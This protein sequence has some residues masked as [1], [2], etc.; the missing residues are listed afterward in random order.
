METKKAP[1]STLITY[2]ILTVTCIM[3]T[4][5]KY[6]KEQ[7]LLALDGLLCAI[8]ASSGGSI[9]QGNP[10]TIVLYTL[11]ML[12]FTYSL[13]LWHKRVRYLPP[14][15]A[16]AK[17]VR[18]GYLK[19][20]A[21]RNKTISRC[22]DL[23]PEAFG[24]P[25]KAFHVIILSHRWLSPVTC[26]VPTA[27]FPAGLKLTKLLQRLDLYFSPKGLT[28]GPGFFGRLARIRDSL[29]GGWDVLVFIDFMGLPQIT[30]D[31]KGGLVMRS[32]EDELVF[33]E[34]LANMSALYSTFPVLVMDEV[35][36]GAHPYLESGWCFS[37]LVVATLGNSLSPYSPDMAGVLAFQQ[38]ADQKMDESNAPSFEAA[39]QSEL[40]TK[41]FS[42]ETD[43][44]AVIDIMQD[45][46]NKRLLVD[47]IR[48]SDAEAVDRILSRFA[49]DRLQMVLDQPADPILSTP[50]HIA[51]SVNSVDITKLLLE[52]GARL[53]L[54]NLHGDL[55]SEWLLLPRL[56]A[57]ARLCAAARWVRGA[58]PGARGPVA[59][60]GLVSV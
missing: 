16:R 35:Q 48:A 42:D 32:A 54:R 7:N 12:P 41:K 56:R 43:A 13:L 10:A 40:L 37:E 34:C 31:D 59:S 14:G 39:F 30:T 4:F 23:P 15:L 8:A 25:G 1:C 21:A 50:L 2:G 29:M 44:T 36:Q 45:F 3:A 24:D 11:F 27:E 46:L 57:A 55:A 38:F 5:T 6:V 58:R 49:G 52:H 33:R 28:K 22:Q 18:F 53:D 51:V 47:A 60:V 17:F 20:L 9:A 26:D 19:H